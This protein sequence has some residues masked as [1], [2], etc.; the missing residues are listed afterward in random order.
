MPRV[1]GIFPLQVEMFTGQ[2][3]HPLSIL[4]GCSMAYLSSLLPKRCIRG[5]VTSGHSNDNDRQL[6]SDEVD[7]R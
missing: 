4:G 6:P 7:K 5:Y 1:R 2:F 3:G